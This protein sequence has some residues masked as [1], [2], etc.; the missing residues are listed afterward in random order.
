MVLPDWAAGLAESTGLLA[1]QMS[2]SARWTGNCTA[3]VY[4]RSA[5]SMERAP[6]R[7]RARRSSV[8]PHLDLDPPRG[9]AGR[10]RRAG[11]RFPIQLALRF[12]LHNLGQSILEGEG[13]VI[14]IS[15]S[16][17]F[18]QPGRSFELGGAGADWPVADFAALFYG[19]GHQMGSAIELLVDWPALYDRVSPMRLLVI[20]AVAR[21]DDKGT[22][23]RI[24]R[25]G[26]RPLRDEDLSRSPTGPDAA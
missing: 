3:R 22:A 11:T 1:Q 20:G 8:V 25:H 6:H 16:G 2:S 26:L 18:F 15:R 10:E 5:K 9:T 12:R 23:V 7:F 13:T 4:Q 21:S 24:L 14:D 19:G 17:V